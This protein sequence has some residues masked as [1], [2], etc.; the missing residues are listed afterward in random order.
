MHFKLR[1]TEEFFKI[2]PTHV[3][4]TNTNQIVLDKVAEVMKKAPEKFTE[5]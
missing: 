5:T 4:R 2:P 1:A 3:D